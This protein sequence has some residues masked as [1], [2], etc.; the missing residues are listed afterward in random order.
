[1]VERIIVGPLH[2]NAYIYSISKKECIVIDPGADPELLQRKLDAIN[3]RPRA[4]IFTHGYL[5]HISATVQLMQ[6]FAEFDLDIQ[7]GIHQE[8]AH[9]LA[10]DGLQEQESLF[11]ST[12]NSALFD[13]LAT[14][15]PRHTF[16]YIDGESVF[17]TGLRVIHTPGRSRGSVCFY[18]EQQG[19]VFTGDTLLFKDIG[20]TNLPEA[21]RT[22]LITS[23]TSQLFTLPPETVVFPGHGPRTTIERERRN[24]PVFR[25]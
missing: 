3:M 14:E 20:R 8:D 18:E 25:H 13:T 21:D 6:A 12:G 2:T 19:L 24:N 22:Q 10:P 4:I 9:L 23:V 15:L 7:V 11:S 1:M 16:T 5:D 17:E